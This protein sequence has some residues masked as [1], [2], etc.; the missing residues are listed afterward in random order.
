MIC[1]GLTGGIGS[2]KSTVSRLLARRGAVVIDADAIVHELQAAGEP[3]L[4]VLAERFGS[5]ILREDGSLDRAKLAA[6]AFADAQT[7]KD[8]NDIVH[9]AVRAEMANRVAAHMGTNNIVVL[10]VPLVTGKRPE[11]TGALVVVDTPV[12]IAIERLVSQRGMSEADAR[13][14]LSNQISRE[15]RLQ[16]ADRVIDNSGDMASLER[17][18]DDV[19]AWMHTVPPFGS[20][21][22]DNS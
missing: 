14:R 6:I 22:T 16:M 15:Q 18:V 1:I 13:A 10:D 17:Q 9:P 5:E 8:L 4:D 7:V 12:E 3:L 21:T 19:W 20:E 11:G 2:G